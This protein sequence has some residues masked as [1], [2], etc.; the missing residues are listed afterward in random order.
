MSD[1]SNA[2]VVFM[3][4]TAG[5]WVRIV[6]GV[7]LIAWGWTMH[8]TTTGIILMVVG[9]VP[10]LTGVF[11]VCLIAPIIGAPFAGKDALRTPGDAGPKP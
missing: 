9:L 7:A 11:N 6:A 3:A 1:G 4:S 8:Q 5:R 2:F 10:L